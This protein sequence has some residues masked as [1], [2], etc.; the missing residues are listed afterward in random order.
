MTVIRYLNYAIGK[1]IGTTSLK[2]AEKAATL[3]NIGQDADSASIFTT[4]TEATSQ[5]E[6][7][8]GLGTAGDSGVQHEPPLFLYGEVGNR[9]G[10]ACVAFLTRWGMDLLDLEERQSSSQASTSN[11]PQLPTPSSITWRPI[12]PSLRIWSQGLSAEW[13]R[14]I[15]SSDELFVKSEM[16][17]YEA[18]K[19][20]V[21]MRRRQK[22]VVPAE[23]QEWDILF[24]EGIYYSH[25]V[26]TSTKS[27]S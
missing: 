21:E 3:E 13:V 2:D 22:G 18:A 9:I 10:E 16:K 19:Q 17:R 24:K 26:S 14:G 5:T 1:G 8:S 12:T 11:T 7:T 4:N 15:L 20:V 25:F 6:T 23:E 27:K